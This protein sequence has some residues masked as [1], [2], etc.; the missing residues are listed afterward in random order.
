M[1]HNTETT[2]GQDAKRVERPT[3]KP[4]RHVKVPVHA[5]FRRDGHERAIFA[6]ERC[7]NVS[8]RLIGPQMFTECVRCKASKI[9]KKMK[10]WRCAMQRNS[11]RRESSAAYSMRKLGSSISYRLRLLVRSF[12]MDFPNTSFQKGSHSH[13]TI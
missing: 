1:K 6:R 8:V 4:A 7:D 2:P 13:D 12:C 11:R 5:G 10:D 3:Q 9:Q